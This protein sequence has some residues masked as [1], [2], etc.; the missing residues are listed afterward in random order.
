MCKNLHLFSC[1][2]NDRGAVS[3]LCRSFDFLFS[4]VAPGLSCF[5][6]LEQLADLWSGLWVFHV[7]GNRTEPWLLPLRRDRGKQKRIHLVMSNMVLSG[8]TPEMCIW[9]TIPSSRSYWIKI[10]PEII[11]LSLLALS[12]GIYIGATVT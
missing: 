2:S 11:F 4:I 9:Y 12:L 6:L 8:T 1:Q 7:A 5:I 10:R 3:W